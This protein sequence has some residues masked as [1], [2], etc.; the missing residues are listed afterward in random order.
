MR[1]TSNTT[2]SCHILEEPVIFKKFKLSAVIVTVMF[3]KCDGPNYK[4]ML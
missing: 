4:I 1:K 3:D 2:A